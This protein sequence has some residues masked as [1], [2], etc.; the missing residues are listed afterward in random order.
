[1]NCLNVERAKDCIDQRERMV[2]ADCWS[3]PVLFGGS[4]WKSNNRKLNI[5]TGW[6]F[7]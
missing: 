3:L 4:L 5:S 2:L 1:M 6:G 7:A